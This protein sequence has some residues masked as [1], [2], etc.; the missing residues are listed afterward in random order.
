MLS[1]TRRDSA[2]LIKGNIRSADIMVGTDTTP[3]PISTAQAGFDRVNEDRYANLYLLAEKS[4]A[5]LVVM[6]KHES[7]TRGNGQKT[8]KELI[9]KY[10][11]VADEVVR[12]TM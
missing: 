11:K 5:L 8:L 6:H 7:G 1:V 3:T 4:V 12:A 10:N 2:S 9:A